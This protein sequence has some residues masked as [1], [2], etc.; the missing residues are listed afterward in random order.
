MGMFDE[1]MMVTLAGLRVTAIEKICAEG[2]KESKEDIEK[3]R[4]VYCEIVRFWKLD[5]KLIDEF[6]NRIEQLEKMDKEGL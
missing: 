5:K 2:L 1:M 3:V 4:D 6:K